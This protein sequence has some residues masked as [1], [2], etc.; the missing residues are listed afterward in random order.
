[1]KL[2]IGMSDLK[3]AAIAISQNGTLISRNLNDFKKVPDL[4]IEDWTKL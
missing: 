2:R 4:R 3:I 1:M